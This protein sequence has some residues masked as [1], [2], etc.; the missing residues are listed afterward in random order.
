M[1]VAIGQ[2]GFSP[3]E[4]RPDS[5]S[6][7]WYTCDIPRSTLKGLMRRRDGPALWNFGLWI[8]LL[9]GSGYLAFRCYG[10]WWALPAF[11]LYGTIYSSSDARWH[12]C[13]HGTAF[14]TRWINE[15]FYEVSSFMTI[16]EA[17]LWRW[18]HSRHHTHTI[19][20]DY[21]PE[22]QVT[23]PADLLKIV[24]DFLY[25]YSGPIEIKRIA[26]HAFGVLTP[27]E[28]DYIPLVARRRTIRSSQIYLLIVLTVIASSV[29]LKSFLPILFVW[30]PRFYGGWLHQL[31]GLTQHAGL[32]ENVYDHRKSTRTVY[33]NPVYRFL[34]MNMNYHIEHHMFPTVPYFSL[35]ELHES[36]K[37]QMPR[38]YA[39]IIDVYKEIV[40]GLIRQ[41]RDRNYYV[42][43]G[44][45]A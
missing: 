16:R 5:Q 32:A 39:G 26:L 1:S 4:M 30:T 41:S 19:I 13:Q 40:P 17:S 8:V 36:I 11:L 44:V 15:L 22:I 6:S 27:A 9:L 3:A 31:C 23:R 20:V 18:S 7:K 42:V 45:P 37:S 25:L 38:P 2:T 28:Q 10:T 14:K 21:D 43:R 35:P 24:C 33:M 12:E 29:A 34:Y